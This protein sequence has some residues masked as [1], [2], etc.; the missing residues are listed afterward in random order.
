MFTGISP[1]IIHSTEL[2]GKKDNLKALE[3][4][5]YFPA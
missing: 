5:C 3:M 2:A 4:L 1:L